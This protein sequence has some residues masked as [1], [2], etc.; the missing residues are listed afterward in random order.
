MLERA[1]E[2]F[3]FGSRWLLAP[4][5]GALVIGLLMLLVKLIQ[6]IGHFVLHLWTADEAQTILGVLTLVDLCF[7]A[8]LLVIVA[9]SGYENFVSKFD[10]SN[11]K[12]WP[13][14]MGTI[15]FTGLKLKLIASI[16]SISSIQLLKA[17]MD[18]KGASDRDLAWLVGIHMIFVVSGLLMALTDRVSAGHHDG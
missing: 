3:L 11:H 17:F 1:F 5:F 6:E 18:V 14:W 12:D 16:V 10:H 13:S 7:T 9:F 4:F 2:S 15:D 8:S